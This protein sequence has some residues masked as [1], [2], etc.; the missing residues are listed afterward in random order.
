MKEFTIP[1]W[2]LIILAI[3]LS[4]IKVV[5]GNRL[6]RYYVEVNHAC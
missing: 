4:P 1:E 3:L 6:I 2:M 5:T